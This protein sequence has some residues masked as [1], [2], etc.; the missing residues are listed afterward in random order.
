MS[1]IRSGDVEA[2][3]IL[4]REFW[5]PL[6]EYLSTIVGSDEAAQD[7]A[8]EAFVRLWEHRDRWEEGSA[9][10]VLFRIGLNIARDALRR[11]KV[12]RRWALRARVEPQ[13]PTPT[14]VDEAEATEFEV[15]FREALE[16]LPARR[17]EV[18]EL[19]RFRGLSYAETAQV[20]ELSR[21]TVANHMSLALKDLRHLLGTF[22]SDS[23]QTGVVARGAE[24]K[25]G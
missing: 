6:V 24:A 25:D 1:R 19:V 2:L 18:F 15:G 5:A 23:D 3:D 22:L 7:A 16:S 13:A 8:Q 17:R 9:Q 21:Q 20:M 4:L 12:G 14:P 10:A 11:A